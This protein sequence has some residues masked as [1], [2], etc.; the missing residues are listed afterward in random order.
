MPEAVFADEIGS[1]LTDV[2]TVVVVIGSLRIP[3][4]VVVGVGIAVVAIIIAE[5]AECGAHCDPRSETAMVEPA[6]RATGREMRGPATAESRACAAEGGTRSA[7]R[8]MRITEGGMAATERSVAAAKPG[9]S[10]H[11]ATVPAHSATRH[12]GR[13]GR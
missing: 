8:G 6:M 4:V 5:A 10:T 1:G 13:G 3:V 7:K 11:S 9:V 12:R 2:L